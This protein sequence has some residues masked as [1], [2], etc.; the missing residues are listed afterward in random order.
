MMI[1]YMIIFWYGIL[2]AFGPDHLTAIADFSIGKSKR[3]T[4]LITL[5]FAFGHGL[6]LFIFAKL[7]QVYSLPEYITEYGDTIS[8]SVIIAMGLYLL[9]MVFSNR[10]HL[11]KHVHSNKEHIH[12]YFGK[13]HAHGNVI[14]TSALGMGALMGIGGVRGMLVTLGMLHGENIE[15]TMVLAFVAG[16]SV[17]FV[18]FGAVI[19]YLNRNLL[20]NITNIRRAFGLAGVISIAVGT[21]MLLA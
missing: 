13:S 5:M 14:S 1:G 11:N 3:K 4:A 17:V 2:H 8:S 12:I 18:S 16:V 10:I 6:M 20:T 19:L 7:L 9:F 21:Q 15:P